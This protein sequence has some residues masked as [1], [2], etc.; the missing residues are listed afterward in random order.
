MRTE[1]FET[2]MRFTTLTETS[3]HQVAGATTT[4]PVID[5]DKVVAKSGTSVMI[6]LKQ[7]QV[8]YSLR[9]TADLGD[10]T[11]MTFADTT[12]S[13]NIPAGSKIYLDH[14]SYY[15][16]LNSK[17]FYFQQSL[18]LTGGT[19]GND[20]LSAYGTSSFTVNSAVTLADGNS[21][22]NRWASQFPIYV[23]TADCTL[24]RIK[25]L[26][27]SDAGTGDDA[28]IS[29][30]KISPNIGGTSN[31]T[32]NLI[33]AFTLTSQNNQNHLFDLEDTPSANQDLTEGQGIFVSIRRTGAL[34]SGVEWYA[35]IG[36]EIT[37]FR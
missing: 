8:F 3:T 5:V 17:K 29:V 10:S 35:D 12:F 21:K 36:F 26:C 30:W 24:A 19:N 20:Y 4:L 33:K 18:Y 32:I 28:V 16:K 15:E 9:L 25:G 37:S 22:P 11:T 7:A 34:N 14:N 27:S 13:Q 1:S 2:F 23:A 31:L 6:W